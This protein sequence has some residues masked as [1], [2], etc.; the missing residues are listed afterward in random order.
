M[1]RQAFVI[2]MAL[3]MLSTTGCTTAAVAVIDE[4][5][6]QMTE[7]ECTSVNIMFGESYC[8]E[9]GEP[10]KQEPVYCYK[11]LGGID[12]YAKEA[13][14]SNNSPRVRDAS[15]LGSNGAKV[16]YIGEKKDKPLFNWSFL[17]DDKKVE[18]ADAE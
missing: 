7:K 18:T 11:T 10:I 8:K 13:P 15:A 17:K 5:I 2:C 12:C 14:Y 1:F 4:K 3:V 6:S 16:E 9:K